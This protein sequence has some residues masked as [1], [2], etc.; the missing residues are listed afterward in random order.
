VSDTMDGRADDIMW[1]EFQDA[2]D[3]DVMTT[4]Y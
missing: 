2:D 3:P 4:K 1:K